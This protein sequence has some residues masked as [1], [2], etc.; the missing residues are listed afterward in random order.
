MNYINSQNIIMTSRDMKRNMNNYNNITSIK[1]LAR[2]IIILS[3]T[4]KTHTKTSNISEILA[5][6]EIPRY[7]QAVNEYQEQTIQKVEK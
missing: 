5:R 3:D 6:R 1:L 7:T 2:I 4:H